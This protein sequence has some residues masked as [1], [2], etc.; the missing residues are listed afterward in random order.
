MKKLGLTDSKLRFWTWVGCAGFCAGSSVW[1]L[2]EGD[3]TAAL[4]CLGTVA[5]VTVPVAAERLFGQRLHT[6]FFLFCMV[7]AMGPMLGKAYK[8]Y[9]L[10]S[11]WDKLLHTAGGLVFAVLGVY[12]AGGLNGGQEVAPVLRAVFGLCFSVA[13]AAVWELFEYGMDCWFAMDM[14]GDT[15]VNAVHSY[16]LSDS[17]GVLYDI[18]DIRETVV[19]GM[20]LP[21]AGYLDIGLIDT[22][23]DVLVETVGAVV[24]TVWQL[25]DG[26]RHPLV[27]PARV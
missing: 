20:A 27:R 7:Y 3:I 24:V 18:T 13:V 16:V 10:T 6:G 12:L 17:P 21:A 1:F 5:L 8:L 23:H 15:L 2:G 4:V 26:G 25:V 9:Y 22:M 14:Q 11:W 19:N